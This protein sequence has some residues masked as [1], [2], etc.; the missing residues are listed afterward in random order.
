MCCCRMLLG[1]WSERLSI[2][3]FSITYIWRF[4]A[5]SA[6][7]ASISMLESM[8]LK[9]VIPSYYSGQ[10]I[11]IACSILIH[12]TVEIYFNG[13]NNENIR[14]NHL[15]SILLLLPYI[16]VAFALLKYNAYPSQVFVGDT[17][18]YFSGM[19]FAVTGILGIYSALTQDIFQR[20]CFWCSSHRSSTSCIQSLSYSDLF[21]VQDID[22]QNTTLKQRSSKA[23]RPIWIWWIWLCSLLGHRL[24]KNYVINC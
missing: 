23:S 2:W 13:V 10:S 18:C 1:R 11:I 3:A 16:A 24:R 12:N 7:I 9:S 4:S 5:Y 17:F 22:F 6:P 21:L 19:V 8:A 14:D 20:L 15:F